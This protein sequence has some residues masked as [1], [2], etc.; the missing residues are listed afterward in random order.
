VKQLRNANNLVM[1]THIQG[2]H[3]RISLTLPLDLWFAY[4]CGKVYYRKYVHALERESCVP[5][6]K[7]ASLPYCV[8]VF[9]YSSVAED[10]GILIHRFVFKT[11]PR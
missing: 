1:R 2:E 3:R 9:S 11:H 10:S 7:V 8:P 4:S 6:I 5:F